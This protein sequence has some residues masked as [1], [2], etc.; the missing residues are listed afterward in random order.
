MSDV[1]IKTAM[2][3]VDTGTAIKAA[4]VQC[5][6]ESVVIGGGGVIVDGSGDPIAGNQDIGLD[7]SAPIASDGTLG[8]TTGWKVQGTNFFVE[9]DFAWGVKVFALCEGE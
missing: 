5:D 7:F 6:V 1:E 4:S 9:S 8:G 2:S 3:I